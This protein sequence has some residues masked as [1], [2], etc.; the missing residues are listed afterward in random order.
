MHPRSVPRALWMLS[1]ATG[2][3]GAAPPPAATPSR[4]STVVEAP[5]PAPAAAA[6]PAAPERPIGDVLREKLPGTWAFAGEGRSLPSRWTIEATGTATLCQSVLCAD[7]AWSF[8]G[9]HPAFDFGDGTAVRL[10]V[11]KVD[12]DAIRGSY[13]TFPIGGGTSAEPPAP[14]TLTRT[15]P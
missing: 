7:V 6:T 11:E 15:A 2:C 13:G 3:G 9:D 14:F 10:L 4:T 5:A 8:V 1:L 12:D